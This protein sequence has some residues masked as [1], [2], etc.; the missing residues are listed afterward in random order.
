M[1]DG[2]IRLDEGW[3]L[4]AGHRLDQPPNVPAPVTP[5][6]R[7]RKH[8]T[9]PD[10]IPRKRAERR[11]WLQ[12]V[13]DK[14]V[15]QVAAAG[16]VTADGTALKG[17]ADA[18]MAKYDATDAAES[19]LD[20]ARA[21]EKD[22]E[23]TSIDAIREIIRRLKV[24]PNFTSSGAEGEL[25]AAGSSTT[26]D[27]DTYKAEITV[28]IKG[29]VI[30]IDFKKRGVDALAIY[31]RLR[32]SNTWTRLAIDTTTPYV[33]TAPLA[34]PNVPEVREYM[35]RGVI[36]DVEIGIASDIVSITFAG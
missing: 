12:N 4:D 33:D 31:C 27:P 29:G 2:I 24:L 32:G 34:N 22:T 36:D 6:K 17:A 5:S 18:I 14:A 26:F 10:F 20:G 1:G 13:S 16:G 21:I 25:Q 3:R 30:T 23:A 19:A 35:A 9:M 11:A 7:R 15:A 8:T 28:S